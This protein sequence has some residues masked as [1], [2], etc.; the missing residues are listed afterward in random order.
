[1]LPW[2]RT[3]STAL[4]E[5]S[6]AISSKRLACNVY[7]FLALPA[8]ATISASIKFRVMFTLNNWLTR[9]A[10]FSLSM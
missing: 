5:Q 4:L 1:M 8:S 9:S 3:N 6:G 7:R 10:V 2:A